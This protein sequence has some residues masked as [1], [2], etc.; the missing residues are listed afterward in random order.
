MLELTFHNLA[1]LKKYALDL[2]VSASDCRIDFSV[3]CSRSLCGQRGCT[4]VA[5]Q[6]NVDDLEQQ[7]QQEQHR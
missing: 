5:R 2:S 6:N 3:P 4:E 1:R 7:E